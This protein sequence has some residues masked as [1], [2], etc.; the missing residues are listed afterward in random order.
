MGAQVTFGAHNKEGIEEMDYNELIRKKNRI[1]SITLLICIV[2][3]CIVNA[4]FTGIAQVLP[5]GIGGLVFTGL[6]LLLSNKV[7]PVVM[8]Y[9]MVVLMSGI[10]IALM[11]AFPCTTNFLMFFLA[12]FFVVIYEDIRPIILQSAVSAV[13]MVVFYFM[14][15]Q[16]LAES[17]STDAM[18]MCVVYVISG[19]LVFIS[20][21]RLTQEQFAQLQ[22]TTKES[23][24]ARKK[25]EKL[26]VE[27]SKSVGVL[28]TTSGKLS[29]NINLT[30]EISNQIADAT[31][32]IARRTVSEVGDIEQIKEMVQSGVSQIKEVADSSTQMASAS[33]ETNSQVQEGGRLVSDLSSQMDQLT[34]RMD[35]VAAAI[36]TLSEENESIIDILATLDQITSQ[37][38]LLSL[39]ASIE[40]ARAGEHGKG[41][42]VVATEIRQL[43]DDSA[44]FTEQIHAILKGVADQ[45]EQ[46]QGEIL[47]GQ[48][49]VESCT[50]NAQDVNYS[51]Q[52]IAENTSQVLQQATR[53]EHQAQA[54]ES[55][56]N[57]TLEN[58]N[59]INENVESTS[60]AM[61]EISSSITDLHGNIDSV[62]EG[63][64]DINEITESLVSASEADAEE[65]A[66]G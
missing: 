35:S 60:A 53:I 21:C 15:T 27:I 8:M 23:D 39:N 46:V 52:E 22:E 17:W 47:Q 13:C 25:A 5:M 18:A 19:M 31:E 29:D 9:A 65:G 37:T 28:D 40:A 43:S 59:S 58:V 30:G 33:N 62:V 34:Q 64:Q 1:L 32:D 20:L 50:K 61:E 16:K 14:Y 55:L 4:Y 41:F 66:L 45:T 12:I 44:K 36:Q 63:Y 11:M 2:L 38:N 42:A 24:H 56:M 51:F 6:L 10:S 57:Q 48:K 49:S 3:R 7:H 26:L 54:L